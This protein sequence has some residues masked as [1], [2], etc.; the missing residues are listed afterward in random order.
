MLHLWDLYV[1]TSPI[2][3]VIHPV[4]A[5]WLP[6]A[7]LQTQSCT[8]LCRTQTVESG[9]QARSCPLQIS[10]MPQVTLDFPIVTRIRTTKHVRATTRLAECGPRGHPVNVTSLFF[11]VSAG[12][13]KHPR[14]CVPQN[15]QSPWTS[16]LT[17]VDIL[18]SGLNKKVASWHQDST[19]TSSL[20]PWKKTSKDRIPQN[21]EDYND[22]LHVPDISSLSS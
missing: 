9:V 6:S 21:N 16:G 22:G 8:H 10:I 11:V 15:L 20:Q 1:T 13:L 3:L 14:C 2:R 18:H 12:K 17:V 4:Y 19:K 7:Y 5:I